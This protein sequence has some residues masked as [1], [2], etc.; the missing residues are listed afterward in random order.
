MP[1]EQGPQAA[2]RV[3]ERSKMWSVLVWLPVIATV[4]LAIFAVVQA[5]G[6][7]H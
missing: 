7:M 4:I 2:V 6:K 5:Y 3:Q 1:P